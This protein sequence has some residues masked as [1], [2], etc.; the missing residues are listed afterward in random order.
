M[1][2][3]IAYLWQLEF[4]RNLSRQAGIRVTA[5]ALRTEAV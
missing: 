5:R 4:A 3:M 1:R 2:R